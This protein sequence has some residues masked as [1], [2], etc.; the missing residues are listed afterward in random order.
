[1]AFAYYSIYLGLAFALAI[2]A[3]AAIGIGLHFERRIGRMAMNFV[4]AGIVCAMGL[5]VMVSR[6]NVSAYAVAG[7]DVV[8]GSSALSSWILRGFTAAIVGLSIVVILSAMVRQGR[9]V[10]N[11]RT[12]FLAFVGYFIANYLVNAIAGTVPSFSHNALYPLVVFT[13]LYVSRNSGLDEFLAVARSFLLIFLVAGL[14]VAIAMP[15]LAIQ[16]G[17]SGMIPG[18]TFR[19][20]GL[21]SHS[22]NLGPAA[23]LLALLLWWR[24]FAAKWVTRIAYLVA[25]VSLVL[26]Q[27]KTGWIA[28]GTAAVVLVGYLYLQ[29]LHR[30]VR[31]RSV[32][33]LSFAFVASGFVGLA[34][35]IVLGAVAWENGV[36]DSFLAKHEAQL[37]TF[38]GRD[39]IWAISLREWKANPIFGYGPEL[40]GEMF[41]YREGFLGVASNSHNQ[42]VESLASAGLFGLLFLCIYLWVLCRYAYMLAPATS[43]VSLALVAIF[44]VRC[45]PEVPFKLANITT[46]DFLMHMI[47]FGAFI[48]AASDGMPR[49]TQAVSGRGNSLAGEISRRQI[50]SPV[51][52][53]GWLP[54]WA[55]EPGRSK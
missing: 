27:S 26:S 43:G 46:N 30:A 54:P 47:M 16:K 23:V 1:M 31:A 48:R 52:A 41:S 3:I 34:L 20:W 28:G 50:E 21:S 32:S 5:S 14:A 15:S 22:N 25:F 35:L 9:S 51:S 24:P 8:T 45:I 29:N 13:A 17:Y 55:R 37:T 12:L 18:L 38:T 33:A 11:G 36:F 10:P 7:Q 40:W 4:S 49:D 44:L 42:F 6:R 39:R 19:Y 53:R 2:A